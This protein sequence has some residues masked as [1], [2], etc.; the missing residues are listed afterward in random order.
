[1]LSLRRQHFWISVPLGWNLL[2][3]ITTTP[4]RNWRQHWHYDNFSVFNVHINKS[5]LIKPK[6]VIMRTNRSVA[7]Q[8]R[9]NGHDSVSNN[10]PHDCLLNR[11]FRRRSKK[12]SK[13]RV[14][15]LC[16][17][18]SPVTGLEEKVFE[19]VVWKMSAILFKPRFAKG[20]PSPADNAL[21]DIRCP[22]Y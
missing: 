19:N 11:L 8:W 1:M 13:L 4:C 20:I 16:A 5:E 21:L 18:N 15:G 6:V 7:L 22:F 9:H 10:Q 12:A 17:G 3:V 14:T 2:V